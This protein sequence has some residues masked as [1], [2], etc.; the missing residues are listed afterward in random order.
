MKETN[1]DDYRELEMYHN[2]QSLADRVRGPLEDELRAAWSSG[3]RVAL[4]AHSMGSI[5]ALDVLWR[6]THRSEPEFAE[7][8]DARLAYF[9]TMGAPLVEERA[10]RL[11]L[12]WRHRGLRALPANIE[13]WHNYSCLG[14]PISCDCSL[15]E[16]YFGPLREHGL[17]PPE[18]WRSRDYLRLHNPWCNADGKRNPHK[19]FGYLVQPR[20]ASWLSDLLLGRC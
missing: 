17:L 1:P 14:D 3:H 5:I 7:F 2:D 18:E 19:S 10:R 16:F 11:L 9:A 20:L 13:C 12:A 6:F 8:R 15:E 4:L